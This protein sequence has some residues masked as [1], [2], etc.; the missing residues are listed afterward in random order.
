MSS[1]LG[2]TSL[3]ICTWSWRKRLR[4]A[5]TDSTC[6][7]ERSGEEKTSEKW[8]TEVHLRWD[9]Y[10][11]LLIICPSRNVRIYFTHYLSVGEAHASID[12]AKY[13]KCCTKYPEC[14]AVIDSVSV[15]G[16][17]GFIT[18]LFLFTPCRQFWYQLDNHGKLKQCGPNK[19]PAS[20]EPGIHGSKDFGIKCFCRCWHVGQDE[21]CCYEQSHSARYWSG[22]RNPE[23]EICSLFLANLA[24]NVEDQLPAK[25]YQNCDE[26]GYVN[27]Y[28]SWAK[29][30]I[31]L[32]IKPWHWV[33][34]LFTCKIFVF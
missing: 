15:V 24:S 9:H 8:R 5:A 33:I 10:S 14:K 34:A 4:R 28:E 29:F 13:Y 2:L 7:A 26:W 22:W 16:E 19:K 25:C 11:T 6:R 12:E 3:L 30:S 31:E 32:D 20:I 1:R 18:A 21:V 17:S 27:I 23:A